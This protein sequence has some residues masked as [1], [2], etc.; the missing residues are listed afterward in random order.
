MGAVRDFD[1]EAV[2]GIGGKG[3]EPKRWGMDRKLLWI[4]IGP[5]KS[6]A[7]IADDRGPLVSFEHFLS[8][9]NAGPPLVD[10][11]PRVAERLY[12]A[13]CTQIRN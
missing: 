6:P 3:H 1:F 8:Y 4:G 12:C 2:I 5:R 9:G 13:G 7:I 11:A 10:H